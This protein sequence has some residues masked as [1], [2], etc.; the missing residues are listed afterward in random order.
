MIR[1]LS[2]ELPDD[3]FPAGADGRSIRLLAVSDERDEALERESNREWLGKLDAIFGCGDLEPDYLAFLADALNAPLLLVRGNHDRGGAWD[4]GMDHIPTTMDGHI[5][6]VAGLSAL[7]LSWPGPARG[8]ATR[9]DLGAWRQVIGAYLRAKLTGRR[10]QVVLSHVP[11]LGHGDVPG[12]P[13]HTGFAAYRWLCQRLQPVIWLHGHTP[14]AAAADWRSRLGQTT[15]VNVT[16]AVLIELGPAAT[17]DVTDDR[18]AST[19]AAEEAA[20]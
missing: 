5:D 4:A 13:Y 19:E 10:P 7:G 15:L 20:A 3:A 16:N 2:L 11:P 8:R 9:T 1:R 18:P 12:D 6:S 17:I 14:V